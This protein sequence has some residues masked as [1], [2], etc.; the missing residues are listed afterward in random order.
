[1]VGLLSSFL[2]NAPVA[3]LLLSLGYRQ[4]RA[5]LLKWLPFLGTFVSVLKPSSIVD[6]CVAWAVCSEHHRHGAEV[7]WG[8]ARLFMEQN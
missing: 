2:P 6:L 1:M 5:Y 4:V 8:G 7:G 3:Y